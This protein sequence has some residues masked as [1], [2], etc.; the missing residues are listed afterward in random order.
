ME[1][2]RRQASTIHIQKLHEKTVGGRSVNQKDQLNTLASSV[3]RRRV[4]APNISAP[5][6]KGRRAR[7]KQKGDESSPAK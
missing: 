6:L 7:E 5:L 2:E 4:K 3:A 1:R